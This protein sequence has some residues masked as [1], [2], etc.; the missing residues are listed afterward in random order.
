MPHPP[1]IRRARAVALATPDL[2][3]ALELAAAW[4]ALAVA[5]LAAVLAVR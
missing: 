1:R 2:S 5:A 4:A 3:R